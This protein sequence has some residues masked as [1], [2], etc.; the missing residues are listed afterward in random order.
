MSVRSAYLENKRG[1]DISWMLL[2]TVGFDCIL[3]DDGTV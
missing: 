3:L 1:I 2:D